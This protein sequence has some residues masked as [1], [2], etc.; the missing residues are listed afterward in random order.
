MCI[1]YSIQFSSL[2][3]A[4]EVCEC[5]VF[6]IICHSVHGS[7]CVSQ[8]AMGVGRCV[9]HHALGMRMSAQREVS[10]RGVC[11]EDVCS[12]ECLP[13]GCLLGRCLAKGCLPKGVVWL[14]GS[15]CPEEGC[16][17]TPSLGSEADTT[18]DQRQT[19]PGPEPDIHPGPEP[20]KMTLKR[21]AET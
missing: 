9:S 11:P 2:S 4:K 13:R 19:P 15:V 20:D 12:G 7:R 10:A 6:T 3:P 18:C 14:E 17:H 1:P 21:V 8:H 5:C 16:L